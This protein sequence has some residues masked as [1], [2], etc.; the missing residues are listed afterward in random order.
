MSAKLIPD[1]FVFTQSNLHTFEYCK[2][3]FY[4]RYVRELIWPAQLVSDQ[5][6]IADQ[7]AGIRFH[8][9]IHQHFLG[10]ELESLRKVAK[11]D[12]DPR[13]AVWLESFLSSP[14][15]N[16]SGDL[17][18]ET[19][20]SCNLNG[21]TL[22]AKIDLLQ[23]EKDAIQIYDWKT[24]RKLPKPE[25]IK[26]NVQ[27]QVYPF[28]IM[29]NFPDHFQKSTHKAI[30]MIYWEANFPHQPIELISTVKEL[31]ESKESLTKLIDE[32]VSLQQ[33][34]FVKTADLQKCDWCEYRSYCQRG[35]KAE[36]T[37]PEI[38]LELEETHP[39]ETED[40]IEHWEV[41]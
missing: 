13:L 15:S 27:S 4:L 16:L 28:V 22:R 37:L 20:F 7:Q 39:T 32:I 1:N 17:Y 21:Y 2:F 35:S 10:F 23:V 9:L 38:W 26:K 5:A 30:T 31:A 12:T 25:W 29:E 19:S 18:P 3:R 40:L 34:E 8:Q 36:S 14:Y 11:N 41:A 33:E 6:Y 24:S